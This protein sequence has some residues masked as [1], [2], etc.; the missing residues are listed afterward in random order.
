MRQ[1]TICP[2]CVNAQQQCRTNRHNNVHGTHFVLRI[3]PY[4]T[5]ALMKP[6]RTGARPRSQKS[7]AQKPLRARLRAAKPRQPCRGAGSSRLVRALGTMT[8]LIINCT[9]V[10]VDRGPPSAS[11]KRTR[12][13][14]FRGSLIQTLLQIDR[15]LVQCADLLRHDGRSVSAERPTPSARVEGWLQ[16]A[17]VSESISCTTLV[18]WSCEDARSHRLPRPHWRACVTRVH[19]FRVQSTACRCCRWRRSQAK[20]LLF[21]TC[22]T[23]S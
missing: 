7:V 22:Q 18:R 1:C 9:L 2:K 20:C 19:T 3:G 16:P 13:G 4:H 15:L 12:R 23:R 10:L 14:L 17:R 6:A 21:G 8:C 5:G 11:S